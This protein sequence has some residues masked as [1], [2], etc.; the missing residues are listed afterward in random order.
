MN[1]KDLRAVA[2]QQFP[3]TPDS[4]KIKKTFFSVLKYIHKNN[5]TGACHA[6][7]SIMFLLLKEQGIDVN[8]YIGEVARE[9]IIFDH[10]WLELDG[11]PID[12]AISNTLI[13]CSSLS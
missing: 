3:D 13:Q 7:S 11:K 1:I 5:W 10:S 4:Y 2:D 12:A 8:L 6:T 9:S